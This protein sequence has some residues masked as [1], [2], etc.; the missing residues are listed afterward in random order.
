[1]TD[2]DGPHRP[3]WPRI[4]SHLYDSG[5]PTPTTTSATILKRPSQVRDEH[6]APPLSSSAAD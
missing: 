3:C 1:M 4:N 2:T 5:V 6:A